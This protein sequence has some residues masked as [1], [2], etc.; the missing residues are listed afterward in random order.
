MRGCCDR[1]DACC[2]TR[3]GRSSRFSALLAGTGRSTG[4]EASDVGVADAS[5]AA[6]TGAGGGLSPTGAGL[7]ATAAV[8]CAAAGVT[9]GADLLGAGAADGLD[10]ASLSAR[11]SGPE[12]TVTVV[13]P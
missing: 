3:S 11:R 7:S 4:F 12:A 1:C 9:P 2:V 6:L 5:A 8:G 10:V 13:F